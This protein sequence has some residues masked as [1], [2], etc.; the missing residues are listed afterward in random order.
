MDRELLE[1]VAA[2]LFHTAVVTESPKHGELACKLAPWRYKS[3]YGSDGHFYVVDVN[4]IDP[5]DYD[6]VIFL[7]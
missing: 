7:V 3:M 5:S 1:A 4:L 2:W 6:L